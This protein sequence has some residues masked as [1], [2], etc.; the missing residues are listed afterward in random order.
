MKLL[1][2]IT[3]AELGGGQTHVAD[4]IQGLKGSIE[5]ELA[6]G[7][8][9][10]L[11]EYA[12][13]AGI[14][15]HV[16][17]DLVQPM[18][19]VRDVKAVAQAVQLIRDTH[20]DLIHAHTS[21]A[22]VI[23]RFAAKVAGVPAVFTAHTWCFAEGTSLKWKMIGTPLERIAGMCSKQIITVSESNRQAAIRRHIA[24]ASKFTTVH[25]GI[26]NAIQDVANPGDNVKI[27]RIVM[28]SR[29]S[30][31]KA[32]GHLIEALSSIGTAFELVLVGDGPTKSEIEKLVAEKDLGT[33]VRFLGQ[34]MDIPEILAQ[35]HLFV[36]SSN[37]EGFPISILEA[38][39]AGLPV[40][41]SDVNG[42]REAIVEGV[43]GF[44]VPSG[45]VPQLRHA[46]ERLLTDAPLRA[47]MGAEG[48]KRFEEQF[49]LEAMLT[50][51]LSVYRSALGNTSHILELRI[52][53]C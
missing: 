9:G 13:K 41:S 3:R 11:T 10:Y 18:N 53:D 22:G 19:P 35:S 50:K 20:P 52:H 6:T 12:T 29:F 26:S 37:W 38:M 33:R 39:R 14:K 44:L 46:V 30:K 31:Q 23:G 45:G 49:T 17:P 21:K 15:W 34:R 32:Q 1:L 2:M 42:C 36:L 5:V 27:P 40:V 4:L 47:R 43:T 51:T 8:T 24:P 25:N 7:E 16:L 48:R 28:V